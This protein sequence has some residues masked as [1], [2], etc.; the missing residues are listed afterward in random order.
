MSTTAGSMDCAM[1]DAFAGPFAG[2]DGEVPPPFDPLLDEPG[3]GVEKLPGRP[4]DAVPLGEPVVSAIPDATPNPAS[5]PAA[6]SAPRNRLRRLGRCCGG[7]F[8]HDCGG[9]GGGS[10]DAN[11]AG[12]YGDDANGGWSYDGGVYEGGAYGGVPGCGASGVASSVMCPRVR[13]P[14]FRLHERRNRF[15][16]RRGPGAIEGAGVRLSLHTGQGD[17]DVSITSP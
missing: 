2:E 7:G 11:G 12:P 3:F 16:T 6:N 10:G 4:T 13:R 5:P 8:D 9:H 1:L 15:R 17:H 14:V